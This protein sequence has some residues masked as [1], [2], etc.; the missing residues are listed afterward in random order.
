MNNKASIKY[1]VI[2]YI[3][4]LLTVACLVAGLCTLNVVKQGSWYRS[5]EYVA[6]YIYKYHEL[7]PNFITKSEADNLNDYAKMYY[8]MGGDTFYNREGHIDNPNKITLIECDIY[9]KNNSITRRGTERLVYFADGSLVLYTAD[10]YETFTPI[11]MW[12][13]NGVSYVLFGA[14]G[15]L[16]LLQLLIATFATVFKRKSK[17]NGF[18]QWIV[19]LEVIVVMVLVVAFSP[20][21]LV[22]LIIDLLQQHSLARQSKQDNK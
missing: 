4:I 12:D 20:I 15:A 6:L 17:V 7:P 21:L 11:T 14:A 22:L 1:R 19:S 5:K 3:C 10:H 13:I 16:V 9:G 8:N 2:F 18:E